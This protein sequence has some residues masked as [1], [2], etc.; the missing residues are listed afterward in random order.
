VH[1][2]VFYPLLIRVVLNK[3][4]LRNFGLMDGLIDGWIHWP[5]FE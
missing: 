5:N 1:V 2:L 3:K 4:K